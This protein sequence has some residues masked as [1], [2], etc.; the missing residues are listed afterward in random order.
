MAQGPVQVLSLAPLLKPFPISLWFSVQCQEGRGHEGEGG[1]GGVL[2]ISLK[3]C[4][5]GRQVDGET[6]SAVS[7][8]P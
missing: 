2:K 7:A 8:S 5:H 4:L 3:I 1:M 6:T